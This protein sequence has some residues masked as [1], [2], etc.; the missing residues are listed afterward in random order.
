MDVHAFLFSDMLLVCKHLSKKQAGTLDGKVRVIRPPYVIDR[1]VAAELQPG[2]GLHHGHHH[3]HH[4][5]HHHQL[6]HQSSSSSAAAVGNLSMSSSAPSSVAAASSSS[7]SSSAADPQGLA[8]V[9]LNEYDV[10]SAAFTLHS[11]EYKVIKLWK[12]QIMKAKELYHEAKTAT[13][14]QLLEHRESSEASSSFYLY[15]GDD[16]GSGGG[17]GDGSQAQRQQANTHHQHQHHGGRRG[18]FRGSRYF[19]TGISN[20]F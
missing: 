12:E 2:G 4:G 20:L 16:D 6:A 8:C 19:R 17:G 10:V 5:H 11:T 15:G 18:S 9:Y 1:L 13:A 3:H 7:S 14:R